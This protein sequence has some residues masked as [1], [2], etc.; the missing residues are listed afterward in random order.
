MALQFRTIE[1][2]P[3][4]VS[5]EGG[6]V[7]GNNEILVPSLAARQ[8]GKSDRVWELDKFNLRG[9]KNSVCGG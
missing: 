8:N 5:R 9:L 3:L 2:F 7:K 6:G 1:L 4:D